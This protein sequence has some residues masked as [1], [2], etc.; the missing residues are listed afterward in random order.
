[1]NNL[2]DMDNEHLNSVEMPPSAFPV[3]QSSA[4]YENLPRRERSLSRV[5]IKN[6]ENKNHLLDENLTKYEKQYLTR[7]FSKKPE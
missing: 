3:V 5:S 1:M 4:F 6:Y 2:V 7:S